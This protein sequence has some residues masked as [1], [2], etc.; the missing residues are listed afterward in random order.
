M[1]KF[2]SVCCPSSKDYDAHPAPSSGTLRAQTQWRKGLL[3][4]FD[5][6]HHTQLSRRPSKVGRSAGHASP[7][8][9]RENALSS[10]AFCVPPLVMSPTVMQT[11]SLGKRSAAVG[12][13][14]R[15]TLSAPWAGSLG[16]IVV[17]TCCFASD[18]LKSRSVSQ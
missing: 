2:A 13:L 6:P 1:V 18:L 17:T 9:A 10:P 3:Q 15:R 12:R 16:F 5:D 11:F 4:S 7:Q 8:D 14:A